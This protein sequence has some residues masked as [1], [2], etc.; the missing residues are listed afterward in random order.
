MFL[1]MKKQAADEAR[2]YLDSKEGRGFWGTVAGLNP[3][4]GAGGLKG[5]DAGLA[6]KRAEAQQRIKD[7][8]TTIDL[9]AANEE[10]RKKRE[11]LI[12]QSAGSAAA[13]A[14]IGQQIPNMQK[15]ANIANKNEAEEMAAQLANERGKIRHGHVSSLQQVGAY[16]TAASHL[17]VARQLLRHVSLI[18]KHISSGGHGP[19]G[20]GVGRVNFGD[21]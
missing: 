21:H 7:Y 19:A 13:A 15:Q 17:D 14:A 18:E 3:F 9:V 20:G 12:K 5:V 10:L 2:K 8:N 4:S 16:T 11:E 6:A 1:R